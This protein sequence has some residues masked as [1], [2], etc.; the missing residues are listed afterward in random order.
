[1]WSKQ[2]SQ[3]KDDVRI[4]LKNVVQGTTTELVCLF[5]VK[6]KAQK[7]VPGKKTTWNAVHE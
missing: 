1:M 4:M 5:F 7:H 6:L 2:N 3:E